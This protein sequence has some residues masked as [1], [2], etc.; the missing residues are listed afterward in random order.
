[1]PKDNDIHLKVEYQGPLKPILDKKIQD[2][3]QT[4]GAKLTGMGTDLTTGK[5]DL[6]FVIS[7]RNA[8]TFK[9]IKGK[10]RTND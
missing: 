4:I 5:R 6:G 8:F 7:R 1:M 3:L 10:G 2:A 9:G